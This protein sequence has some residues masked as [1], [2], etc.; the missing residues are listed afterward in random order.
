MY[1]HCFQQNIRF[2]LDDTGNQISVAQYF[3][4]KYN[5]ALNYPSLP[6]IQAGSDT[7]PIYLP[8]EVL[9]S[10]FVKFTL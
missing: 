3:L 7:K 1:Q 4:E 6:A 8:M 10:F 5:V 2:S 9:V